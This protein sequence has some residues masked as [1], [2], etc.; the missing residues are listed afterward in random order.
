[1]ACC[2]K[3]QYPLIEMSVDLAGTACI[4]AST[5]SRNKTALQLWSEHRHSDEIDNHGYWEPFQIV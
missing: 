3:P 1:M 5:M 2:E 4:A